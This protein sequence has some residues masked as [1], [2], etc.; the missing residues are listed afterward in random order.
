M[1]NFTDIIFTFGNEVNTKK[2]QNLGGK[3]SFSYG[4]GS[5]KA[6]HLMDN[7][8]NDFDSKFSSDILVIGVNITDWFYT[9][10]DI[11]RAY[12]DFLNYIKKLSLKFPSKKII[13][14]H[15]GNFKWNEYEK[16]LFK[17]TNIKMYIENSEIKNK[18][19]YIS[20]VFL[21]EN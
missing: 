10:K 15:H 1:F 12:L 13:Y 5:L 11:S 2:I 3:V 17:D 16:N 4:V 7:N 21:K 14:K 9:S 8:S 18:V 20:K 19:D 6:E